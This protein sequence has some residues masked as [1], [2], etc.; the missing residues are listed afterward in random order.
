MIQA[1][2]PAPPNVHALTSLRDGGVSEGPFTS[3]NLGAH[4]G[5]D[6]T[7]VLQN[8]QRFCTLAQLPQPPIWLNQTH[9]TNA[10]ELNSTFN[11]NETIDADASFTRQAHIPCTV[12]TADCLPLLICNQQGT[13]VAAIHAGWRGLR[14][15]IISQTLDR[16]ESPPHDLLVWLGPAIA[17]NVFELNAEIRL[18]FI[19]HNPQNS[20]AFKQVNSSWFADIFKLARIELE[21]LGVQHIFGGTFCTYSDDK[22]FFSYRRDGVTGRMASTIWLT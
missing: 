18:D 21:T 22:R 20:L 10:I 19:A 15:G 13:E 3:L 12:M 1:D 16:L 6:P 2:W 8:R 11:P 17:A 5:D 4:V 9:S 7:H 14:D